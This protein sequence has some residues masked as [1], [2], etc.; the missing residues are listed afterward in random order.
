MPSKEKIYALKSHALLKQARAIFGKN[1]IKN[2]N[3][4]LNED[5]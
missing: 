4:R 1:Q 5:M 2:A 3:G